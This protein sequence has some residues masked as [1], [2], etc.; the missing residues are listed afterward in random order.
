MQVRGHEVTSASS[1][2]NAVDSISF[3]IANSRHINDRQ[4]KRRKV[5]QDDECALREIQSTVEVVN[6]NFIQS[7]IKGK[8]S[9]SIITSAC[10]KL[11]S[12]CD[13][14]EKQADVFIAN[15]TENDTKYQEEIADIRERCRLHP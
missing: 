14:A 11:I 1:L 7:V 13:T 10:R 6:S 15:I 9:L 5:D 8:H 12:L 2:R 4:T 3:S